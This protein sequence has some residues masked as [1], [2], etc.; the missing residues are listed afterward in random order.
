MVYCTVLYTMENNVDG[1]Y[2]MNTTNLFPRWF[3]LFR[4]EEEVTKTPKLKN[5][6][7]KES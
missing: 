1:M 6:I 7:R 5:L 3:V 2:S 4:L